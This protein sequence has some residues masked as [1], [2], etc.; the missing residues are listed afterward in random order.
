MKSFQFYLFQKHNASE[1]TDPDPSPQTV[2]AS[3]QP[4]YR[5][6]PAKKQPA[7]SGTPFSL[8]PGH[9]LISNPRDFS[10][11]GFRDPPF[12]NCIPDAGFIPH[13]HIE[14]RLYFL[15]ILAMFH[16]DPP[17]YGSLLVQERHPVPTGHRRGGMPLLQRRNSETQWV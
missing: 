15:V 8:K 14:I 7:R 5:G 16:G 1:Q 10:E 3:A 6:F 12:G 2:V 13:L 11:L 4:A 17:F 9:S